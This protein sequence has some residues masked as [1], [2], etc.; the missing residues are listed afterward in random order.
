MLSISIHYLY[1]LLDPSV[2]DAL[3]KYF[4]ISWGPDSPDELVVVGETSLI[5]AGNP[6]LIWASWG[7]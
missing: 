3:I 1:Y 4:G 7:E 5:V 2:Q 6:W